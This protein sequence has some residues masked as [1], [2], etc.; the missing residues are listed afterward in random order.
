MKNPQTTKTQSNK[1]LPTLRSIKMRKSSVI[2]FWVLLVSLFT[3]LPLHAFTPASGNQTIYSGT[4]WFT[5]TGGWPGGVY[6]NGE[7]YTLTLYPGVSGYAVTVDI[8]DFST[9]ANYDFLRIYNGPSTGYTQLAYW[10]GSLA[11]IG[12]R[13]QVTS[14][15]SD[16][17]LTI[18]WTSDGSVV[19]DGWA[20]YVSIV[21]VAPSAP[22]MYA[23]TSVTNTSFTANWSY[24]SGASNYYLEIA[25]N[26]SFSPNYWE[27]WVG[28]INYYNYTA[29][30]VGTTY[31][32]RVRSYNGYWS[33]Y[34]NTAQATTIP[35]A[36]TAT[37]AFSITPSS[38]R[39]NWNSSSGASSYYID[40]ATDSGFSNYNNYYAGSNTYYD[41][42]GL[43]GF[44][45]YYYR[46]RAYNAGGYSGYSGYINAK[47]Q[48]ANPSSVT[49]TPAIISTGESSNLNAISQ[50]CNIRWF[51][52]P[53]GG[54]SIGSSASGANFSV[55]PS[56]TTTYY[57][58]AFYGATE[59][60]SLNTILA[61]LNSNYS[62]IISQIPNRYNFS[63]DG[64]V[65][66]NVIVD[67]GNDM[68]DNGNYLATN[69]QSQMYYSDNSVIS[70][71]IFGSGGA[72]F[73][74]YVPGLFVL[75]AD[76]NNVSYF[77]VTGN[78]GADGGGSV[79]GTMLTIT[80]NNI[81]YYCYLKRVY[82][83]TDPSI[84]QMIIIPQNNSA[85]HWYDTGNT[86][87]SGQHVTNINSSTRLYYLLY[88]GA[89]GFYIDNTNAT[90]IATAFLTQVNA[91]SSEVQ[92][93]SRTAVTVTIRNAPLA[94]TINSPANEAT[95]TP[96]SQNLN[97]IAP[98]SGDDPTAYQVYFG[99]DNPPASLIQTLDAPAI[100]YDPGLLQYHNTYYWQIVPLNASGSAIN[101]PVWSFVTTDE[102]MDSDLDPVAPDP[103][104]PEIVIEPTIQIPGIS[105]EFDPVIQ[106]G[107]N[108]P[109]QPFN[110]AGLYISISSAP[111]SGKTIIINPGLGFIPNSVA[112]RLN[113]S[114]SWNQVPRAGD[115]TVSYVYFTLPAAKVD[116]DLEIIFPADESQTLAITLSSFTCSFTSSQNVCLD[117]VL[118]SET[119]H[120]GYNILRSDS[121][122]LS[123]AYRINPSLIQNGENYGTEIHYSY[124]DQEIMPNTSYYYWLESISLSMISTMY[125][126]V[127]IYTNTEDNEIPDIPLMT[128]LGKAYPNP[129]N[130]VVY[131][132][133]SLKEAQDVSLEIF[134]LRGQ[135]LWKQ[136]IP[137]C[138]SGNHLIMWDGKDENGSKM[139]SGT[140]LYRMKAGA[141]S[142]TR[143]V[144]MTK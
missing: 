55:S 101:C 89:G 84:N 88:A 31:Y 143:K 48:V 34:S 33:G 125:G 62:N 127:Q 1:N 9:E 140:Y 20:A 65:N 114:S 17:S 82:S 128:Q 46:V 21:Q 134:N 30:S 14:S 136:N 35:S 16:G 40:L 67:G 116:D 44:T 83:A 63:M 32:I 13:Q 8:W 24:V 119:E 49:A 113:S 22:T 91:G 138:H 85:S 97:W 12:G 120:L 99:T 47:T 76:M 2:L 58:E 122:D 25:T 102:Y 109:T 95:E 124:T 43:S 139:V 28:N 66:G 107:W 60:S 3:L 68:Y 11:A 123:E 121:S 71:A 103:A 36:P 6:Q 38:F 93:A 106:T 104:Q 133:F 45:N 131:I 42:S 100:S 18:W 132:P 144:I 105:G 94:A 69:Y 37:P 29:A 26:A 52:T 59:F 90:N 5:D 77:Q 108:P 39:A 15:A 64:G 137:N 50:N 87:S 96:V 111:L 126:P 117:W 142:N 135:R 4:T 98:T 7:N 53:T 41:F 92:S 74:R 112:Y 72:Y 75:T 10:H 61:N 86:D 115:W 56:Q 79:D 51:T 57:A 129:F 110:N 73:T 130:P 141:Y 54:T 78:N 19:A 118:A 81:V 80:V 23:P 27:S 70:S